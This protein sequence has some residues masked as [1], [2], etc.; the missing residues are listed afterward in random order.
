[1]PTGFD[2]VKETA[3]TAAW[4]M[5]SSPASEPDPS[6]RFKTPAGTPASSKSSTI[7]TAVAGVS[8]AGLKTTVFPAT[9]AGAIFQTGIATG[10]FQGVTQATT[11]NGC[12]IV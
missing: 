10:K 2:P 5:I 1:M 9:S 4:L 3:L 6:T 11:P 7:R 12:F 8:V